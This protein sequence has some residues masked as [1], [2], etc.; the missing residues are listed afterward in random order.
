MSK[1]RRVKLLIICILIIT[2]FILITL[3]IS[4]A[5][6]GYQ[7]NG[8]ITN[9]ITTAIL[10]EC[11]YY[12]DTIW[13]FDYTGDSQ[14]FTVPCTGNYKIELWGAESNKI[15]N[16][17]T[18]Y[19]NKGS[20]TTGN[21]DLNYKDNL[22][23]YTG[24][25]G[26]VGSGFNSG[27]LNITSGAGGGATD[28]RLEKG[29][30][31]NF[32]SLKSRL[33]VASG[34]GGGGW[35]ATGGA[36][37]TLNGG[38]P[39]EYYV[40]RRKFFIGK[41]ATQIAGGLA[42]YD[43]EVTPNLRANDGKFGIGGGGRGG[44]N[45]GGGYYGGGGGYGLTN[46]YHGAGGGGSS[47]IS[48]YPGCNA[49]TVNSTADNIIHTGQ[50]NHYSGYVFTSSVMK[51]GNE[52]MPTHDGLSTMTGNSGNGYAKITL[53]SALFPKPKPETVSTPLITGG[54]ASWA[55]SR[56]I[57]VSTA[58][59]AV[60]GIKKYQ[61]YISTSNANQTGGSW[62]DCTT[63]KNSQTFTQNG[64]KYIYFRAISNDGVISDVSLPQTISID[65]TTPTVTI[66]SLLPSS[67]TKG[68]SYTILGSYSATGLSGGSASCSSNINGTVT[69]T[70]SLTTGTH[71][72]TCTAKT[73]A[74]KTVS[75]TK[76]V[77]VTYTPYS[78]KNIVTN[79]SFENGSTSWSLSN[80]TIVTGGSHGGSSIRFSHNNGA[81][82]TSM[83]TQAMQPPILNH[84]YYGSLM[85]KS[86]TKSPLFGSVMDSRY[87]WFSKDGVNSK[88]T[89]T[90]KAINGNS[91][92]K[93]SSIK[94]ITADTYLGNTW[95]LRNF[96]RG[97][98]DY[99]YADA[100]IIIDLTATFGSGNEPDKAWCDSHINY[101][102][103]T[104]TIYK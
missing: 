80:A 41:G 16:S 49:I 65:T 19:S 92:V 79:G 31:D 73:G 17:A 36:G 58:S 64:T 69:N 20:Y 103:G 9:S 32:N 96:M 54:S 8:L 24:A 40:D 76:S 29:S 95:I 55:T 35:K 82:Y 90:T 38:T 56:T 28:I 88:M 25:A 71:T 43:A 81:D 72:I 39:T 94:T 5:L 87:E 66:N 85:F 59:T 33:M 7:K 13:I 27:S 84:F 52:I 4:Y 63:S 104:T 46:Y 97:A 77:K 44:S 68:D 15:T 100:L 3:G 70:S 93:L 30:W 101:F 11:E 57:S 34:A 83:S 48:G 26:S 86:S 10:N 53:I 60:S 51:S 78:I 67:L 42:G 2:S 98:T 75:A 18:S 37:G 23:I 89:F 6:F 102:D 21:I 50:A 61:Y 14:S 99:T 74:G 47:F 45:G 22:Y 1:K 91:W 12:D 62:L